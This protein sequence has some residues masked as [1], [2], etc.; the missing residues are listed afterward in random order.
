MFIITGAS[1]GLGLELAKL[2]VGKKKKVVCLSRHMPH[3]PEIEWLQTD[4]TEEISV[5]AAA[6]QVLSRD[7]PIEALVN[8][9]GV[10]GYETAGK[11]LDYAEL[12]RLFQTNILGSILLTT[13]LL[14]RIKRDA[15]DIVNVASTVGTRANEETRSAYAVSKWAMRGYSTNLQLQLKETPCRVISFCPG[16]FQSRIAEK[17]T[18]EPLTDPENWMRAEDV[19][20]CLLQI[21][22]LPKNMQVTEILIDRKKPGTFK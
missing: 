2:L 22:E 17:V 5:E 20:Q 15:G 9:A 12:E 14:D 6:K 3:L 8:C 11:R 21:M 1:E 16:G 7:E 10:M 19:A 4:L 13:R 18:G